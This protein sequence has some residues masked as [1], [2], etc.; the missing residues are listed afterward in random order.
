MILPG[1]IN[2][3][4]NGVPLFVSEGNTER[5]FRLNGRMTEQTQTSR[6]VS[7]DLT[8]AEMI[9]LHNRNV[10]LLCPVCNSALIAVLDDKEVQRHQLHPGVYCPTDESHLF[11]MVELRS[12][13]H[14]EFW[15]QFSK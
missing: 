9:S 10:E 8:L 5:F 2:G 1:R 11:I 12:T 7:S 3:D 13:D 6:V 15:E 14:D 4:F